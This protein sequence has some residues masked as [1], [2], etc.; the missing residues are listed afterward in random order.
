M[1]PIEFIIMNNLFGVDAINV[2]RVYDLKGSTV[3]RT[4]KLTEEEIM[5]KSGLKVLKDMNYITLNEKLD[6]KIG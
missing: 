5:T 6:I 1:P 3:G 4:A 2:E